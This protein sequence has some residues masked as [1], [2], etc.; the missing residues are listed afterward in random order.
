MGN[1][2]FPEIVDLA[3]PANPPLLSLSGIIDMNHRTFFRN[4]LN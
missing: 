3:G 4:A 2:E 1:D